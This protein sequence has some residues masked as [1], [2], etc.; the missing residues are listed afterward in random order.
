MVCGRL[1]LE[2]SVSVTSAV[3]RLVW[4]YRQLQQ[5]II[6]ILLLMVITILF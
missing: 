5:L 1:A 4:Y 3:S 2:F 6:G